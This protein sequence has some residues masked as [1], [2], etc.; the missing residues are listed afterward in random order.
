MGPAKIVDSSQVENKMEQVLNWLNGASA[1]L[2][3][4]E[5][6]AML[7]WHLYFAIHL[8]MAME[9]WHASL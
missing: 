2:H 8:R 6:A 3:P 9:G 7:H 4:I 1:H 5:R